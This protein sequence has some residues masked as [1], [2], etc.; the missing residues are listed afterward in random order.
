MIRELESE[1]ESKK[2]FSIL[3]RRSID[4]CVVLDL[5]SRCLRH[6]QEPR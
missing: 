6:N 2:G 5:K 3:D 4:S 1:L